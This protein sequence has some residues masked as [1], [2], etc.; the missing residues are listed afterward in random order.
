MQIFAAMQQPALV[1]THNGSQ[2]AI[3]NLLQRTFSR[4]PS[5]VLPQLLGRMLPA[6]LKLKQLVPLLMGIVPLVHRE[7]LSWR[8]GSNNSFILAVKNKEA[9]QEIWFQMDGSRFLQT[10]LKQMGKPKMKLNY[11]G[12]LLEGLIPKVI[13]FSVPQQKKKFH[14][15][16]STV[17]LNPLVHGNPFEQKTPAG[18]RIREWK[19]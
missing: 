15:I 4:G 7:H 9:V 17:K 6:G 3:H 16:Y 12:I 10:S 18:V 14:W 19:R 1:I 13:R 5:V 8:T 2:F 11:S